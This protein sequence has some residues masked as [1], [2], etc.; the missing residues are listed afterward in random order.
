M[1]SG[2][3]M[4]GSC[5][6]KSVP[7]SGAL[8]LACRQA[9]AQCADPSTDREMPHRISEGEVVADLRNQRPT[10]YWCTDCKS[11]ERSSPPKSRVG[12]AKEGTMKNGFS[13]LAKVVPRYRGEVR[14]CALCGHIDKDHWVGLYASGLSVA[15]STGRF[16]FEPGDALIFRFVRCTQAP[17]DSPLVLG[18][19]YELAFLADGI[20]ILEH[21][22]L[23]AI[24]TIPL[25]EVESVEVGGPGK[26][27]S[28]AGVGG[29]GFSPSTFAK[30]SVAATVMNV[31]TTNIQI[32]THILFSSRNSQGSLGWTFIT[33]AFDPPVV[34]RALDPIDRRARDLHPAAEEAT[35]QQPSGAGRS[36]VSSKV[37]EL[38]RLA[39]LRDQGHLSDEEFAAMKTEILSS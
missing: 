6:K 37:E 20:E 16:A 7:Q 30:A 5:G 28:D 23:T 39:A 9:V 10:R 4:C 13:F 15:P 11:C 36:A 25:D 19:E 22:T 29:I 1:V 8:C 17:S 38:S 31:A 21:G 26:S 32:E 35:A 18:H 27:V 14:R 3:D 33:T 12:I 24:E 2:K 34:L